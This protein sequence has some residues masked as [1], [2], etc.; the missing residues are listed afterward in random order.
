MS[1]SIWALTKHNASAGAQSPG[2]SERR[3]ALLAA[4]ASSAKKYLLMSLMV[5]GLV[6]LAAV[7]TSALAD[8]NAPAKQAARNG[9]SSSAQPAKVTALAYGAGYT[10]PN[11]SRQVRILQHR[12]S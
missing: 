12:L 6:E 2:S 1:R 8:G 11:G 10:D 9:N 3:T 7:P 5:A 4:V